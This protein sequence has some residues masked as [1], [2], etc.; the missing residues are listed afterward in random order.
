MTP[1]GASGM[2]AHAFP[3]FFLRARAFHEKKLKQLGFRV[4][5]D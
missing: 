3:F 5:P 2:E 4:I 1:P